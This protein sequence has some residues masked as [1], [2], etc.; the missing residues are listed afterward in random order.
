MTVQ[1]LDKD[2][3]SIAEIRQDFPILDDYVYLDNA[4]IGA[5]SKSVYGAMEEYTKDYARNRMGLNSNLDSWMGKIV[6]SKEQFAELIGCNKSEVFFVPTTTTGLNIVA[7]MVACKRGS[8]VV[9]N[10]MEYLSNVMV[11]LRQRDKGVQVRFVRNSGGKIL[12]EDVMRELD[13]KTAVLTI[14]QV[15]WWNG[16]R[17]DTR[18]LSEIAHERGAYFVVDGIQC[19]G[20]MEVDVKREGIDF[21]VCG[22]HKWLL[23]PGGAAFLYVRKDL[24]DKLEPLF[25][26]LHTLDKKVVER[27]MFDTF[28]LYDL[29]YGPTSQRHDL[30]TYNRPAYV[31]SWA[32]MNL[33]LTEGTNRIEK[34]VQSLCEYLIK[35]LLEAGFK[36]QTP[37]E[38]TERFGIVNIQVKNHRE[39]AR[40]LRNQ[41][42]VIVSPRQGG[43]RVSPHFF[44]TT[45]DIDILVD[46]LERGIWLNTSSQKD[47]GEE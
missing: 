33:I 14:G 25:V 16:F 38:P 44:N 19:V 40:S 35:Q 13:D 11:W 9:T 45:E 43:I 32:S 6:E 28:D 22:T 36:L 4:A 30:E 10:D 15:G 7:N 17:Y 31:G 2:H 46:G 21:L 8:N 29:K 42:R 1:Y 12:P 5:G 24:V 18:V 41:E 27:N 23:G 39:L 47:E 37:E 26:F 34:R 3:K 20:A